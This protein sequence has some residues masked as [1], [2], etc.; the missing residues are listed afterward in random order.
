M[1]TLKMLKSQVI[2]IFLYQYNFQLDQMWSKKERER[3]M[4]KLLSGIYR[5]NL[6]FT[7][8]KVMSWLKVDQEPDLGHIKLVLLMNNQMEMIGK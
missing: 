8:E 3:R 4:T 1:L 5:K 6:S 2:V 7:Q